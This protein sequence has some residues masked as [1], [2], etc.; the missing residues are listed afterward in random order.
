PNNHGNYSSD[1]YADLL[2]EFLKETDKNKRWKLLSKAEETINSDLGVIPLLQ[3]N[4]ARL[5]NRNVIGITSNSVGPK[6]DFK[7][8]NWK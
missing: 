3:L 1:K 4:N 5:R 2:N 8:L 6:Y 7:Y